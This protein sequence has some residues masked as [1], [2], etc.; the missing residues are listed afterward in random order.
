MIYID[1]HWEQIDTLRDIS[2]II[3]EYYNEELAARA[4]EIFDNFINMVNDEIEELEY[5]I[6]VWEAN[7]Y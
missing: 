1:G 3:R 2:R 5:Q 6:D 4:D 7:D